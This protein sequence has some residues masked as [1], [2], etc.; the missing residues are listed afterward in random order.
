MKK[1][2]TVG[3]SAELNVALKGLK[4]V[5]NTAIWVNS[6]GDKVI[7]VV[8]DHLDWNVK[9]LD[10][11]VNRGKCINNCGYVLI[12]TRIGVKT[13]HRL[14]ALAWLG[15]PPEGKNEVDHLDGDKTNNDVRNLEWVS[16]SENVRR[17]FEKRES[18]HKHC[19]NGRYNFKT[20]TFTYNGQTQKM[21][22]VEYILWRRAHGL[23]MVKWM[24]N[25]GK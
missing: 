18:M 21:T 2:M 24:V 23:P 19:Y 4:N 17:A 14:V 11:T 3:T 25:Y 13:V 7:E 22:P 20:E 15:A 12:G 10:H 8:D 5:P 6:A 9:W 1:A 16:H